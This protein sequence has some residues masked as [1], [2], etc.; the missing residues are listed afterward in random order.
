MD[1]MDLY[2]LQMLIRDGLAESFPSKLWVRAEIASLQVRANGHCYM[3]LVQ[4]ENGRQKAKVKAIIWNYRY[5]M[6]EMRYISG[7][8]GGM[9]PGQQILAL[10]QVNYSELYGLSL[11]IDEVSP[12]FTLGDAELK[13]Q[14]TIAELGEEGLME[15]Q[16]SLELPVL[17]SRLAVISA[18]D[19]AGYG[20]FTRHLQGNEYGFH[21]DVTLFEATM[22]GAGAP[23]SVADALERVELE[24]GYDAVL[25]MRGGGSALD[26]ACFDDY[27][28]CRA[29]AVCGIPVFTAIGH[30]RDYHVADMVAYD[31]VKTPTALADLF[32]GMFAAE[33]ERISSF[34]TRL[35][36]A[37]LGR[38][39]AMEASLDLLSAR[40]RSADP[41]IILSRG[42][43]L[44][45][46]ASGVVMKSASCAD[47][48]DRVSVLFEDGKLD[49]TVNGKV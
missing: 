28:M 3:D 30:D 27:D 46:D 6:V 4:S 8:G 12:E 44:V 45:T 25:I 18:A 29:I 48:G 49:C 19:A 14:K 36:L 43:A 16:K 39:S 38:L 40:I 2:E 5:P 32:I 22:Q 47:A 42:Y 9:E 10:C 21:F 17:P 15:R 35:R 37:F 34:G 13:K 20:D 31:H 23:V 41:R 26:L 33:D 1:S 24:G 7:T 11:I